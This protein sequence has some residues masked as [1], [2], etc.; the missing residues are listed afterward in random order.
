MAYKQVRSAEEFTAPLF[1]RE[2]GYWENRM[3]PYLEA[4]GWKVEE[5]KKYK[6]IVVSNCLPTS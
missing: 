1:I 4:E 5:L 2:D 3:L 6:R